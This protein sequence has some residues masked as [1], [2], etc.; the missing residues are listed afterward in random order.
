MNNQDRTV[1]LIPMFNDWDAAA[2]LL[3]DLDQALSDSP[4]RAEILFIDDG[5]TLPMPDRFA[6]ERFNALRAVDILHLRRNL[7]HQRAIAVGLVHIYQNMPCR[8]VIVMD[9]DGE[10]RPVDINALAKK[11][12]ELDERSIVFAAR[13]KR[14]ES[15]LF[16]FLYKVYR[17]LHWLLTGDAVRVGNF[18]MVPFES[19][20]RLV[21][22]PEIWNH[23]AAAVIRSRLRF[24][25][26]PISRG[27]RLIGKSKMNFIA[28]LLHGLSAFF[29]YGDI[30]GARLLVAIAVALI[31]EIIAVAIGIG[32]RFAPSPNVLT[33]AVY[34]AAI[35]GI[36]LL[37]AIPIALI[38]VFTVVG[39]SN[40]SF[41]PIRDCPYFVSSVERIFPAQESRGIMAFASQP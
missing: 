7:G 28:L 5:S 12:N 33:L 4:L 16:R 1:I 17:L 24:E 32:V 31:I 23:Y 10:D 20:G 8:A 14:L 9:A 41:L 40:V 27:K 29:V 22:V 38:L 35:L 36:I 2:L 19:L 34:L 37:Q 18:S 25:T 13:A 39:R 26:I 6:T 15:P 30:V 3:R 11:F 21:V